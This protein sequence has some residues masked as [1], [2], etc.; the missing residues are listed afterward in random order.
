MCIFSGRFIST[1]NGPDASLPKEIVPVTRWPCIAR[2]LT[3]PPR[4]V[5]A[6]ARTCARVGAAGAAAVREKENSEARTTTVRPIPRTASAGAILCLFR[7]VTMSRAKFRLAFAGAFGFVIL[8]LVVGRRRGFIF[9]F[10]NGGAGIC[11]DCHVHFGAGL[12][13][14]FVA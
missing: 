10:R 1:K 13:F 4:A 2:S 3:R 5:Y 9:V 11:F 14:Y 6:F 8:R 7:I 12:Q